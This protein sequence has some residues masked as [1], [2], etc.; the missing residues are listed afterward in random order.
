MSKLVQRMSSSLCHLNWSSFSENIKKNE[1]STFSMELHFAWVAG[2]KIF[3]EKAVVA[4]EFFIFNIVLLPNKSRTTKI[5][6]E[7][8]VVPVAFSIEHKVLHMN[9]QLTACAVFCHRICLYILTPESF[10]Y[11]LDISYKVTN[12]VVFTHSLHCK[13]SSVSKNSPF[14]SAKRS[15]Q[16]RHLKHSWWNLWSRNFKPSKERD[17]ISMLWFLLTCYNKLAHLAGFMKLIFIACR[18]CWSLLY[19]VYSSFLQSRWTLRA[20]KTLPVVVALTKP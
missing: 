11:E 15:P 20:Y 6:A 8:L 1:V 13:P 17:M 5:A 14:L 3:S 18:T 10:G 4:K 2:W 12:I 7:T 19:G 16:L 9:R